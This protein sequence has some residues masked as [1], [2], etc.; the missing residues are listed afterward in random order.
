[1][2]VDDD[3][4]PHFFSR[5]L[6]QT[7]NDSSSLEMFLANYQIR[8]KI[9]TSDSHPNPDLEKIDVTDHTDLERFF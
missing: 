8:P 1:M 3:K 4:C 7:S 5:T 2:R 6:S 9:S